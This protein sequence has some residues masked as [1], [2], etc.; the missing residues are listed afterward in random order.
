MEWPWE[1]V[2][3]DRRNEA[4]AGRPASRS[5]SEQRP[6]SPRLGGLSPQDTFHSNLQVNGAPPDL[7][8]PA[9][10]LHVLSQQSP[11]GFRLTRLGSF[12]IPIVVL[13]SWEQKLPQPYPPSSLTCSW[14]CRRQADGAEQ[15]WPVPG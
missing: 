7:G 1:V 12:S 6:D 9:P 15:A 8:V 4:A 3:V 2:K 11:S 10:S 13:G 5:T 14:E